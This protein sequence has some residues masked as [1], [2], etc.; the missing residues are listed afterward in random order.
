MAADSPVNLDP[1][2]WRAGLAEACRAVAK[3]SGPLMVC[4]AGPAG[5]GKTTL[6]REIRKRGLPGFPRREVALIDDGVM[7]VPLLGILTRRV[8]DKSGARDNLAA[9]ARWTAGKSVVVYVA[10]RPWERLESCD[11]LL[12]VHC[13]ESERAQRQSLRGKKYR[14]GA[15]DPPEDWAAGARVLELATG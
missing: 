6:G 15:V 5:A 13:S 8:R 12:R 4:L 7:S 9:F 14:S 3:T 11:V 2:R 10:I 1:A